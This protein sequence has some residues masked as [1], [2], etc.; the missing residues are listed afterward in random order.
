VA[1]FLKN[2]VDTVLLYY[3]GLYP[4]EP[5]HRNP[6]RRLKRHLQLENLLDEL[7]AYSTSPVRL[8]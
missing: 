5:L 1:K 8:E 7:T 4:E 6:A 2:L 3:R